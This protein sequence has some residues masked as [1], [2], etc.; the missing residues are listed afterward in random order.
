[1]NNSLALFDLDHT[2][3]H[4]DSDV[5]WSRYLSDKGYVS[6][7]VQSIRKKYSADYHNGTLNLDEFLKFQLGILSLFPRAQ[8]ECMHREF[9]S[10]YIIPHIP[11]TAYALVRK[12]EEQGDDLLLVSATNEF[13]IKPIA[14]LF[15][16]TEVIGVSL[17]TDAE[18]NYTGEYIGVPSYR[19]GKVLRV[20]EWLRQ[21]Q[22]SWD[23]Y[24]ASY[25][26]SDSS[27]D[28]ALLTKVDYPV[29]VNPDE[30]L[31][32]YAKVQNWPILNL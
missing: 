3:L 28:L 25:F 21:R 26:Y 14:Q 2:L 16:I 15:H 24:Q 27:N 19:E 30:K 13:I 9:L 20:E 5:E 12:H 11:S 4:C 8:L 18:G 10:E 6:K 1:M 17:V 32:S 7:E 31:Y 22:K 23:D 29:A